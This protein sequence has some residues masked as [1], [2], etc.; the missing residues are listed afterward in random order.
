[1]TGMAAWAASSS[2]D[3]VRPGPGDD[4]VDEALEVAGHVADR[5]AGAHDGVLGR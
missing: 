5:L 4:P 2:D 1:M 3:L